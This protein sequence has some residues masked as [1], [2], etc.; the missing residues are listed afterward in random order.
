[1]IGRINSVYELLNM[2]G[3][4]IIDNKGKVCCSLDLPFKM[5]DLDTNVMKLA[6]I[7][8][9]LNYDLEY[10]P[11]G[12]MNIKSDKLEISFNKNSINSLLT[13]VQS[14]GDDSDDKSDAIIEVPSNTG[15]T[16]IA[17]NNKLSVKTR[18]KVTILNFN[19]LIWVISTLLLLYFTTHIGLAVSRDSVKTKMEIINIQQQSL[20]REL[21]RPMPE[22]VKTLLEYINLYNPIEASG[23]NCLGDNCNITMSNELS[24]NVYENDMELYRQLLEKY[25]KSNNNQ[26]YIA[27][28]QSIKP[29]EEPIP[30]EIETTWNFVMMSCWNGPSKLIDNM[31][32]PYTDV[33]DD[34][35][36]IGTSKAAELQGIKQVLEQVT[37]TLASDLDKLNAMARQEGEKPINTVLNNL[38][39]MLLQRTQESKIG[40]VRKKIAIAQEIIVLIPEVMTQLAVSTPNVPS[41]IVKI[42]SNYQSV[43]TEFMWLYWV[44]GLINSLYMTIIGYLLSQV[45]I[46][47]E[48]MSE[49]DFIELKRQFLLKYQEDMKSIILKVANEQSLSED[50]IANSLGNLIDIVNNIDMPENMKFNKDDFK[51]QINSLFI[52]QFGNG[53]LANNM[54]ITPN[55]DFISQFIVEAVNNNADNQQKLVAR[56]GKSKKTKKTNKAIKTKKSK[57]TNNAKKSKKTNRAKKSKKTNKAKKSK[58]TKKSKGGKTRKC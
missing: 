18:V 16:T 56:G 12:E 22:K 11:S 41:E 13:S 14:G 17:L 53:N 37:G 35:T 27:P 10:K 55:L 50:D 57:K 47:K 45:K 38:Y 26:L 25:V 6:V 33:R 52:R 51:T 34:L 28:P 19:K 43:I 48:D 49:E 36:D 15:T 24:T 5:N 32:K 7:M 40:N 21:S 2:G 9:S 4:D 3:F 23:E 54:R 46:R 29:D 42:V 8:F 31:L 58:K 39:D 20:K 1:M 44:I 30:E